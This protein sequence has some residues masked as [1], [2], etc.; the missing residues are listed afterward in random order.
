MLFVN[1]CFALEQELAFCSNTKSELY[2]LEKKTTTGYTDDKLNVVL[3]SKNGNTYL[4]GAPDQLLQSLGGQNPQ[5]LEHVASGHNILY[6]YFPK[7][8][9]LTIQKSYDFNGPIMVNVVLYCK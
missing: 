5:Y 7:N 1:N 9:I 2:D 4:R 8:K 3:Y 6:T